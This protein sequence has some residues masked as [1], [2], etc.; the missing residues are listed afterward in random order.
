M[1]IKDWSVFVRN[2]DLWLPIEC[3]LKTNQCLLKI[4][5]HLLPIECLLKTDQCF[6]RNNSPLATRRMPIKNSK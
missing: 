3:P 5:D 1:P 4:F 2:I 6:F